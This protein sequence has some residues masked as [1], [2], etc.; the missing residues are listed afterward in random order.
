[1]GKE[2]PNV[3]QTQRR[4]KAR[5]KA[6]HPGT[7]IVTLLQEEFLK[8]CTHAGNPSVSTLTLCL[9]IQPDPLSNSTI[10]FQLCSVSTISASKLMLFR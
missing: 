10:H 5:K 7:C 9:K 2:L 6:T 4:K 3:K 1:M 8:E